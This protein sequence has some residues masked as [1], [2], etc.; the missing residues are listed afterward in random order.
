MRILVFSDSHND[1]KSISKVMKR[2]YPDCAIHLGDGSLDLFALEKEYPL[3]TFYYVKGTVDDFGE[4]DR[5]ISLE[6]VSIFL[7][8]ENKFEVKK[9]RDKINE[10][11]RL[12]IQIVLYG[13]THVP[14]FFVNNGIIF[15]NPGSI[16]KEY[17][18]RTFGLID[19]FEGEYSCEVL[20]ADLLIS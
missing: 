16:G 18:Y 9:D 17:G 8:H 3:T 20:F 12:N 19:A 13:H 15:M 7:S 11:V 10:A 5:I 1:S 6:G 14:E 2:F 4:P